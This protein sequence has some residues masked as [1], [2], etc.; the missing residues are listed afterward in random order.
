MYSQFSHSDPTATILPSTEVR[1]ITPAPQVA[2][3]SSRGPGSQTGNI[4]KVIELYIIL[5]KPI[6]LHFTI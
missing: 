6:F 5:D 2:D 4:L 3:F 1:N